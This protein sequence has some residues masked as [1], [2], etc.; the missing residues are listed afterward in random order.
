[1]PARVPMTTRQREALL[2]LPATEEEVI[3]HHSLDADDLTAVAEARTPETRL[4]YALQLCALRYPGRHLQR[5]EVL[6]AVMLDHIAEQV[7]VGADALGDFARRSPTRYE[8]LATIKR[9]HGFVDLT[10]PL[11]AELSTWLEAQAI[12]VTDGRALLDRLIERMRSQRVIIPGISVI[13]RMAAAAM[14]AADDEVIGEVDALLSSE[15]HGGLDALLSEKTHARQSH[16]SWLREP[17]SRVGVRSLLELL[18]K[19]GLLR[20]TGVSDLPIPDAYRPRLAQMAREG[21][22]GTAQAFQQMGL[23]RRHAVMVATLRE[24]EATLTDAALA[25]FRSLVGR[26]SLRAK[27]RLEETIAASADQGRERLVRIAEVLDAMV[28]AARQGGDIAGAVTAIAGLDIIEADAALIRRTTRQ[29]R[30]DVLGE[31]VAEHRVFKQVGPRFL[32]SFTFEG[33]RA[34]APLLTA[35]TI[36]RDLGGDWRKPLPAT[37]PLGHIEGRWRHHVIAKGGIDRTYYELATFFALA[38]ALASG[39]VWVPTSRLHR[40]LDDLLAPPATAV[41]T[42]EPSRVP[43]V[44]AT[45]A[46]AYL[47]VRAAELDGALLGVARGLSAK[48]AKLFAGDRLRFPKEPKLDDAAGIDAIAT[49]A[50]RLIPRVRLTDMLEA[51]DRWTDFAAHFEHVKTGLPPSD[52]RAF[53]ATLIAE[54]TN[55][56]LARMADVCGVASQRALLRMLT[57]HMREET[58]RAALGCLTDAIHAEPLSAWFGE[59]W[60]ASADGQAYYLGG[61]GEA[62]GQV[63]AHY[64]RDPIVKI[65]TT[66][67]DRYAPLHQTVIAGTAGE[68]IHALDG[69]LG[70]AS[71]V[72]VAALHVDGG[73]VSDIVFAVMHLLGLDFEPRIPRLSDR[74]LY[75]FEPRARYQRLAPLFGQRLDADLIR[76]HWDDIGRVIAALRN[77]VV[78]P[79]LI[80]KKLSAYHQQNSLAAALREVG[81]IERTLFTLRW[82]EDPTLRRLVTA[83]LNKGEAKNS[84]SRA[85]AFHRLGRFRDRGHEK[86]S[87]RAAALNLVTAAIILFNCRYLGRA[88]DGLRARGTPADV[89]LIPQL[90]PLGWD[91]INLTGDYVWSSN[92]ALDADGYMPLRVSENPHLKAATV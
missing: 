75:A 58:F 72:D 51:V 20:A 65:Y 10:N 86:Q 60:R 50:Y 63:N 27:K 31:L 55:L 15:Q 33:R 49:A 1:M 89:R 83:E 69:I 74:R 35:V 30:P 54:A 64:G 45:S 16:L 13:E 77:R 41:A 8:Q 46:D 17:P 92:L 22:R 71:S 9:R 40:S 82:F 57:W 29:G 43:V 88:L 6:P 61:P 73:G 23:A 32:A 25:M 26:A 70:H 53:L 42:T 48:D 34:S 52:T 79:S 21:V 2:A 19:L 59:G 85:V 12:G 3:R 81:R 37:L 44:P 28:K 56:G 5:G 91:H 47:A 24:L 76:A 90:S 7:G 4:G 68:A 62:G 11:R 38:D 14:H 84:L 18:D 66:I 87:N 80:L 36:L 78:T 67:T 39:D